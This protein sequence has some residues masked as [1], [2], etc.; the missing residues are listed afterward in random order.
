MPDESGR[1]V[2]NPISLISKWKILDNLRRSLVE[3]IT[4]FVLI[5]GWF[6]MPGG[7]LYWT[8]ITIALLLLPAT[9]QL[10]FDLLQAL[11]RFS[12]LAL[13]GALSSFGASL[14]VAVIHLTFLA[15]QV[16]LSL[17][18]IVRSIA[19]SFFSGRHL[20]EWETAAQAESSNK[21][22]SLDVYLQLSP[23]LALLLAALLFVVHRQAL[24]AA[25][26]VL[27]LW[28]IAPFAATWLN[29]PPR[30]DEGPLGKSD[31]VFLSEQAQRI[32]RFYA[33]YAGE[34]NH[35][36]VPDHV[37][38]KNFHQVR[39]LTPTNIG[40]LLNARLAA[41]ELNFTTLPE[42][43]HA[44]LRSLASYQQLEKYRGHVFNWYDLVTLRPIEPV[45]VSTVDSGNLAAALYT[46]RAGALDLIKRPLLCVQSFSNVDGDPISSLR[47]CVE[48]MLRISTD[49]VVTPPGTPHDRWAIEEVTRRHAALS[50]LVLRFLPW[51][52]PEFAPLAEVFA[53][54]NEAP[55][56]EQSEFYFRQLSEELARLDANS[57]LRP[58]GDELRLRM[59]AALEHVLHLRQQLQQISDQA[60]R[61]AE[62][63]DFS[64]LFVESRMLLSNGFDMATGQLHKACFDLLASEARTAAFLAVAKGEIPQQSWFRLG[65]SHTLVKGRAV[66]LSWTATMFEH[67]MPTL[68]MRSYPSTLLA[69][70]LDTVIQVQMDHVRGMPWGISESGYAT[71]DEN[72]RYFYQAWGVP[73]I[74]LNY[75]AQDGPVISPYSTFLALPLM[76]RAAMAN[77]RRMAALGW[78]GAYG[79]YEA[80]DYIQRE[81][82]REPQ[83]VRSWMAHHQGM[84]L[85]AIT[86]V[87]RGNVFQTWFHANPRVRAA[88]QLLHEKPLGRYVL[89][90][91]GKESS[92]GNQKAA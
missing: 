88:E 14:A 81:P 9:V 72:G 6:F 21:R 71:T 65:R 75:K 62:E 38:E 52:L 58:L 28:A 4:F 17:D 16:M 63:M 46:L 40:M 91:L 10:G 12:R 39:L 64:F 60:E 22:T 42:F 87:L 50:S 43:A 23:L 86:N 59:Q 31:A 8:L 47:V 33:D 48:R 66:L 73:T 78:V 37:E 19:R 15:H 44:T 41:Y 32:W 49:A 74:A 45:V 55:S 85:L 80:V 34:E 79:F 29:S 5:F 69:D 35:W 2:P 24:P 54:M 13:Q 70:S 90:R 92:A 30:S 76:R 7:A 25:T 53:Q 83:I 68:W 1:L 36:L 27:L 61:F 82:R 57:P 20:L 56:I 84:S 11:F 51:L 67:L 3:P 18:A 26:P 89:N 77:L